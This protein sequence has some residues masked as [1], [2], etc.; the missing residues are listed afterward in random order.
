M[1]HHHVLPCFSCQIMELHG[2]PSGTIFPSVR[3][4]IRT[5]RRK[6]WIFKSRFLRSWNVAEASPAGGQGMPQKSSEIARWYHVISF[7]STLINHVGTLSFKEIQ[8]ETS[9]K[10]VMV[11][12]WISRVPS[13]PSEP[14]IV[15][16]TQMSWLCI[17]PINVLLQ[18]HLPHPDGESMRFWSTQ[19]SH[20]LC[21]R[22]AR[23][24]RQVLSIPKV[25]R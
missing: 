5:W 24:A 10:P 25:A 3:R 16:W 20:L 4:T 12:Y 14:E 6:S 18:V 11:I 23:M 7:E 13:L 21:H 19:I 8:I 15:S 22:R 9:G 1:E 17:Q 2:L